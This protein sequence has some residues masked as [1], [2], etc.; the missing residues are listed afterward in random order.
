MQ[1]IDSFKTITEKKLDRFENEIGFSLPDSY[2]KFLLKNNGGRPE[3]NTF[4]TLNNEIETDIQYFFGITSGTYSLKEKR[5]VF[6]YRLPKEMLAIANDSLG[7][8]ILLSF[9]SGEILF[10]DHET[11]DIILVSK[12]FSHFI[13]NLYELEVEESDF[14]RAVETQN[15][16]FFESILA[17]GKHVDDILNEFDQRIFI[18][19]CI[20][21]KVDL[22][23]FCVKKGAKL[24]GGLSSSCVNGHVNVIKFLIQQ[25][26]NLE[27][28][29]LENEDGTPLMIAS[30]SGHLEIVKLL[31]S[32]GA[33]INAVDK[34]GNDSISLSV[35]GE[36]KEVTKYLKS[37]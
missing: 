21:G 13:N 18:A 1:I 8:L 29:D 19:G 37:E 2:S 26:V 5:K 27:E 25:G 9:D 4:K 24:E 36:H 23:R 17:S 32:K 10:Y 7:N 3:P 31:V 35:M 33:D 16:K 14:D 34:Y 28:T 6:Q 12:S 11:D 20:W 22:V 15:I 30:N